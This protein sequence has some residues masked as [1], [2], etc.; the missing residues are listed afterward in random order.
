MGRRGILEVPQ[1]APRLAFCCLLPRQFASPARRA[2]A[3]ERAARMARGQSIFKLAPLAATGH[4]WR[5]GSAAAVVAVWP[6]NWKRELHSFGV[7]RGCRLDE[8]WE[9]MIATRDLII[10]TLLSHKY[11]F[12][13]KVLS[14]NPDPTL[15]D[16]LH[17]W[18]PISPQYDM[19]CLCVGSSLAHHPVARR[20]SPACRRSPPP[21]ATPAA[22]EFAES[23]RCQ[24][25]LP[26]AP[27]SCIWWRRRPAARF[28]LAISDAPTPLPSASTRRA[29]AGSPPPSLAGLPARPPA[30]CCLSYSA[31]GGSPSDRPK[32][33]CVQI[34]I[35]DMIIPQAIWET[36]I[37]RKR[38]RNDEHSAWGRYCRHCRHC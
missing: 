36:P 18:W 13:R 2:S 32:N 14:E 22:G 10:T 4:H 21:P 6:K 30:N 26:P 16:I 11:L 15:N 19:L 20:P 7:R 35:I 29:A 12:N 23:R 9:S 3:W 8:H 5:P 34:E 17:S 31:Y 38:D 24:G 37:L 27:P 25:P 1:D 33:H 28:N